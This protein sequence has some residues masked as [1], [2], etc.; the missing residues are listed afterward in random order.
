MQ[1]R[2]PATTRLFFC[3]RGGL[4]L[5]VV[6]FAG[7]ETCHYALF[8]CRRG[9]LPLRVCLFLQA[10]R[11]ATTRLV[12]LQARRP[13][14]TRLVF[15]QARRPATTR[16]FVF[17]GAETCHYVLLFLIPLAYE[18]MSMAKGRNFAKRPQLSFVI[19][20][21]FPVMIHVLNVVVILKQL[22]HFAH[23]LDIIGICKSCICG[24]NILNLG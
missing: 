6:V 5:R 7:A 16:L 12:F 23:I 4:P 3:R 2:R 11:P 10:R 22:K 9:S 1:A 24:G 14:T 17:A 21:V 13:A 18:C 8:F 20:F 15:L 19:V